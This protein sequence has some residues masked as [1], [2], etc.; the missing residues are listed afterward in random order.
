MVKYFKDRNPFA[1]DPDGD[2]NVESDC[3]GGSSE[4]ASGLLKMEGGE[5]ALS[6]AVLTVGSF[7]AYVYSHP[8]PL[9]VD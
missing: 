8:L 1:G 2:L 4:D 7:P 9:R 5:D 3:E 6:R